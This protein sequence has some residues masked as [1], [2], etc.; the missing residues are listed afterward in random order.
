MPPHD[1]MQWSMYRGGHG[2]LNDVLLGRCDTCRC[3]GCLGCGSC[4]GFV[5]R[6]H[7][8]GAI[9]QTDSEESECKSLEHHR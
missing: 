7:I 5:C 1:H 3:V 6:T 2:S 9:D 8:S 4:G